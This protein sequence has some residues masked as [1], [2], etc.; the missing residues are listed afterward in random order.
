VG[1]SVD[2]HTIVEFLKTVGLSLEELHAH[3]ERRLRLMYNGEHSSYRI[4]NFR[5]FCG[6]KPVT[7]N[8]NLC[9][10]SLFLRGTTSLA[11][12]TLMLEH[13]LICV[14][15][16]APADKLETLGTMPFTVLLS[17]S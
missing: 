7:L 8:T 13:V 16:A 14:K 5:T 6:D 1:L 4:F 15:G 12:I 9:E 10:L 3:R 2:F 17:R 11:Y